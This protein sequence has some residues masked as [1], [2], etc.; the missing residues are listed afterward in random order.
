MNLWKQEDIQ[1]RV[2][3]IIP[4]YS[5]SYCNILQAQEWR[6]NH[7]YLQERMNEQILVES[8]WK[9]H[10]FGL[11]ISNRSLPFLNLASMDV[12]CSLCCI[13]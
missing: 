1:Q 10:P 3:E 2:L 11:V 9:I 7:W 13:P 12:N 8:F 4:S 6:V 5:S